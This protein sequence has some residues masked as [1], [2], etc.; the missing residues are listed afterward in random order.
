MPRRSIA[1]VVLGLVA[2]TAAP[3]ARQNP[4]TLGTPGRETFTQRVVTA[5]LANPWEVTWGPDGHL[6]ITERTAL[7][8]TRVNPADGTRRV[9]LTLRSNI[10]ADWAAMSPTVG[11]TCS[12]YQLV[13][14]LHEK[15]TADRLWLYI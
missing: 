10:A 3:G 2:A 14:L 12:T 8:V 6:W 9:A 7:R 4:R 13:T 1:A 15:P 11:S 5:D